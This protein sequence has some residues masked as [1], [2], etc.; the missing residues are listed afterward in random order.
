VA[1]PPRKPTKLRIL[2]GN[3]SKRPLPK[4]EPQPDPTM[5]QCPDWL[6]D[7]AKHEWERVAPELNRIGLLTIIDQTALAGYCQSYAKWKKAE[8]EIKLLKNT[9][10]PLKDEKGNIKGFQQYPQY[11]IANQCL[12]QIRAFCSEFGLTPAARAKMELPTERNRDDDFASKLRS[13]IG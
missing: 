11:G 1:G 8:E 2:E 5:P 10:Y 3:P 9:I 6:M 7:D 4:N 13:K 12:K